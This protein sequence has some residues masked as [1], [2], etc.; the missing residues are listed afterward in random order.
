MT[1]RVLNTTRETSENQ[2]PEEVL[3]K[4]DDDDDVFATTSNNT[5]QSTGPTDSSIRTNSEK[6]E[7]SQS[8]V[9]PAPRRSAPRFRYKQ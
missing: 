9:K 1:E 7:L 4:G 3:N 8:D 6:D 2:R 5:L